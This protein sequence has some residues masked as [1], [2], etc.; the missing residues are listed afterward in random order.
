MM[1]KCIQQASFTI[2]LFSCVTSGSGSYG[3]SENLAVYHVQLCTVLFSEVCQKF[4]T[5]VVAKNRRYLGGP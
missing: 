2:T 3:L 4:R 5:V 1:L